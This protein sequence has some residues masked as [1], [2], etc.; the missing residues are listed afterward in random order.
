MDAYKRAL[1]HFI[2]LNG[3]EKASPKSIKIQHFENVI[4]KKGINAATRHYYFRHF[5]SWWKYLKKQ[6]VVEAEYFDLLK[7]D[8]PRIRENTRPK[9]ISEESLESYSEN[10]IQSLRER[11]PYLNLIPNEFS[12]GSNQ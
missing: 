4:F 2:E 8:L 3:L 5:R 9:M 7:E 6:N 11:K 1:E 10:L 12:I